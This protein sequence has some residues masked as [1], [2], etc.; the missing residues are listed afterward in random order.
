MS[1]LCLSRGRFRKRG[2]GSII[3]TLVSMVAVVVILFIFALG[4]YLTAWAEGSKSGA[5]VMKEGQ[6]GIYDIF[7]YADNFEKLSD[8]RA[9]LAG[10]DS[11][12]SVLAKYDDKGK[13]SNEI[14]PIGPGELG[15]ILGTKINFR[16][17]DQTVY[18]AM[19]DQAG[20]Y[21]SL[22]NKKKYGKQTYWEFVIL[23]EGIDYVYNADLYSDSFFSHDD[24]NKLLEGTR[25]LQRKIKEVTDTHSNKYLFAFPFG[26]IT[27]KGVTSDSI[28][29]RSPRHGFTDILDYSFTYKGRKHKIAYR[30]ATGD[31]S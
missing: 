6:V 30:E 31:G 3:S 20:A 23:Q 18:A 26:L 5:E 4:S 1:P 11:L 12:D 24:I 28:L 9:S 15:I 25:E 14:V 10:G 13:K 29:D 2:V 16:G 21:D 17:K 8:A 19:I 27:E 22:P 7:K